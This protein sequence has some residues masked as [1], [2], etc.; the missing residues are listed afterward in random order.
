MWALSNELRISGLSLAFPVA[1]YCAPVWAATKTHSIGRLTTEPGNENRVMITETYKLTVAL[2]HREDKEALPTGT[3]LHRRKRLKSRRQFCERGS[4]SA[5]RL[6]LTRNGKEDRTTTVFLTKVLW[7]T[8]QRGWKVQ[9]CQG[10][11]GW[12]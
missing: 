3:L 10:D 9:N 12:R 8:Q 6:I 7:K 4:A 5:V 11:H 2:T 1:K